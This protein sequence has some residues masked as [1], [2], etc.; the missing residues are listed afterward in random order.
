LISPFLGH[1]LQPIFVVQ[2]AQ[3]RLCYNPPTLSKLMTVH[4]GQDHGN[5]YWNWQT[6]S[7]AAMWTGMIVMCDP[8]RKDPSQVSFA[9]RNHEVQALAAHC[10]DQSFAICVG[11]RRSDRR[12]QNLQPHILNRLIDLT[13]E[14]AVTE[15]SAA[16]DAWER[17]ISGKNLST[18][19]SKFLHI[20]RSRKTVG[21]RDMPW[22]NL[23]SDQ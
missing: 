20:E 17:A 10:A 19:Q 5:W 3:D 18:S 21:N 22:E 7:Q 15:I 13:R 9:Q 14:D 11:L 23:M 8:L 2:A 1:L 4:L 16:A 12:S 6:R